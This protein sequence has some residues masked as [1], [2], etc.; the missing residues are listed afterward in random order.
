MSDHFPPQRLVTL[1]ACALLL[2]FSCVGYGAAQNANPAVVINVRLM[3][4][5]GPVR[6]LGMRMSQRPPEHFPGRIPLVH[7]RN[8]SSTKTSR[9]WVDAIVGSPQGRAVRIE[10]SLSEILWPTE[11]EIAPGGE[12]WSKETALESDSLLEGAKEL[13]SAC[14]FV[15]VR[16]GA[17]QFVDGTRWYVTGKSGRYPWD[18][19][20][21]GNCGGA[22]AS[23]GEIGS[24]QGSRFPGRA[25]LKL[26]GEVQSFSF[27]C[28][29]DSDYF[30]SCPF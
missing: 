4:Q 30:G 19:E 10:S 8:L 27:T 2:L 13:D 14:I 22:T 1:V 26:S 3:Q 6:I 16:V 12:V 5:D 23:E 7:L 9:I 21:V 29:L 15:G 28:T 20:R 18:A 24:L 11:H 25:P 17:V